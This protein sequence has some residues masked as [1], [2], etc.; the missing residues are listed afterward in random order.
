MRPERCHHELQR[1]S[2]QRLVVC[3]VCQLDTAPFLNLMGEKEERQTRQS[4]VQRA[5]NNHLSRSSRKGMQTARSSRMS[6]SWNNLLHTAECEDW[7]VLER[8][9]SD[10]LRRN[11]LN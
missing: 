6:K 9:I 11:G 1:I 5:R 3:A 7:D 10:V 4:Q 2:C 8:S